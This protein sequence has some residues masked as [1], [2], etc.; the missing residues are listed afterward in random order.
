MMVVLVLLLEVLE[1]LLMSLRRGRRGRVMLGRGW[2]R[3]NII[4]WVMIGGCEEV[5]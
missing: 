2:G 5:R 1:V 4:L 3:G